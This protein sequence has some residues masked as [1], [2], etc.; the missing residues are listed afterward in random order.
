M[1]SPFVRPLFASFFYVLAGLIAAFALA[2]GIAVVAGGFALF[3]RTWGPFVAAY[4]VILT[5]ITTIQATFT[6]AIGYVIELLAKIEW[7]TRLGEQ[8]TGGYGGPVAGVIMSDKQYYFIDK[9]PMNGPLSAPA[10]LDLYREGKVS[11]SARLYVEENGQRRLL[12][13]WS[14]VGL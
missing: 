13:N 3:G 9:G 8:P 12:K 6:A 10:M 1:R 14:E 11:N 4:G 5:V 7:N 2:M